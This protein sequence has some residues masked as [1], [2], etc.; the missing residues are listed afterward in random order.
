MP[1]SPYLTRAQLLME[2]GRTEMAE[3][4]LRRALGEDPHDFFAHALLALCLAEMGK[5][6]EGEALSE[7][8]EAVGLAPDLGFSYYALA[9]VHLSAGRDAEAER[10]IREAIALDPDEPDFRGV[11]AAVLLDR[12]RW[13]EA[14]E[15]ADRGLETDPDHVLCAN[16]RA[17]ALV[18]LGRRGEAGATLQQALSRDPENAFTHANQGWALLH[19][20]ERR[21][22]MEHF[23]ESLRLEPGDDWARAGLVEALKAGNPLYAGMLRY[24]LWMTRLDR[25]TQWMIVLG[26]FVGYRVVHRIARSNPELAPFLYPLMAA[27][28]LFV[29]LS[30]TADA[31]FNFVLFLSPTGRHALSREQRV[32]AMLMGAGVASAVG[33]GVGALLTGAQVAVM[34]TILSLLLLVPLAASLRARPGTTRRVVSTITGALALAGAAAVLAEATG[35]RTTAVTLF[36][37]VM[38]GSVVMSWVGN[39]TAGG[40]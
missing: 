17:N 35:E 31:F 7:A 14:L 23:R 39:F 24:F 13:A 16:L 32:G 30:W 5:A 4:E 2:Q 15:E 10:A 18:H 40:R 22:A 9:R 3:Q 37:G 36:S 33:F 38:L 21:A 8:Q 34:G 26:G 25:R 12:R 1:T 11:L 6:R 20:G 28:V 19:R 27:Y 29:L